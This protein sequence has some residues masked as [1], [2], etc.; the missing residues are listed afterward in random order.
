[1]LQFKIGFTGSCLHCLKASG[2][3]S[4]VN[5]NVETCKYDLSMTQVN[6]IA[7]NTILMQK[8][9]VLMLKQK[10]NGQSGTDAIIWNI[11][12]LYGLVYADMET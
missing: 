10:E 5:D 7:L 6:L 2:T 9:Y 12:T 3:N 1:M 8:S 4:I 11:P